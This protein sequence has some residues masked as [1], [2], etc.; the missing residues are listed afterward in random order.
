MDTCKPIRGIWPRDI[1]Q[2]GSSTVPEIAEVVDEALE[3]GEFLLELDEADQM[4][5][6]E[7]GV[8]CLALVQFRRPA[9]PGARQHL[10]IAL[11]VR[12]DGDMKCT[13]I[14]A[15]AIPTPGEPEGQDRTPIRPHEAS[16]LIHGMLDRMA[17]RLP[18]VPAPS[19]SPAAPA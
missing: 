1:R 6:L 5:P 9:R 3:T 2:I 10:M 19:N 14:E 18:A 17:S 12:P 15:H 8:I 7:P 16:G 11:V 13:A 4:Y